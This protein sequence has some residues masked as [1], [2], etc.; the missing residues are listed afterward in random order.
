[1][2][3]PFAG[4]TQE[5]AGHII[6]RQSNLNLQNCVLGVSLNDNMIPKLCIDEGDVAASSKEFAKGRLF[7]T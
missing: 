4:L 7:K 6:A 2:S 5:Q 1:M 3:N